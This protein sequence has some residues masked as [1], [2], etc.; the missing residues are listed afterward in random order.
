[1]TQRKS[2]NE[3]PK[4]LDPDPDG[5]KLAL[6]FPDF[7]MSISRPTNQSTI[8]PKFAKGYVT[9]HIKDVAKVAKVPG[10]AYCRLLEYALGI[11]KHAVAHCVFDFC[12]FLRITT[13]AAYIP[14][15]HQNLKHLTTVPGNEQQMAPTHEATILPKEAIANAMLAVPRYLE[16]TIKGMHAQTVTAVKDEYV[17]LSRAQKASNAK[18]QKKPVDLLVQAT[19]SPRISYW[20]RFGARLTNSDLLKADHASMTEKQRE[21]YNEHLEQLTKIAKQDTIKMLLEELATK[22]T[23]MDTRRTAIIQEATQVVIDIAQGKADQAE[24]RESRLDRE[25]KNAVATANNKRQRDSTAVLSE[26]AINKE[27]L[28]T[29]CPPQAPSEEQENQM[30][31]DT[32]PTPQAS[33]DAMDQER[34][35]PSPEPTATTMQLFVKTLDGTTT[36]TVPTNGKAK[37]ILAALHAKGVDTEAQ[38]LSDGTKNLRSDYTLA[39][40]GITNESTLVLQPRLRG[41]SGHTSVKVAAWNCNGGLSKK[42]D[43]VKAVMDREGIDIL[44]VS[45]TNFDPTAAPPPSR[46]HPGVGCQ[47]VQSWTP[48]P[49]DGLGSARPRSGPTDLGAPSDTNSHDNLHPGYRNHWHVQTPSQ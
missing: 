31:V 3:A 29:S 26:Y 19:K 38:R 22:A 23:A 1:M 14:S 11:P 33:T 39:N 32:A 24:A 47:L 4:K 48:D 34:P 42:M 36:V 27:L 7:S 20:F 15:F 10:N 40:H 12:G 30:Q 9:I 21:K 16:H 35:M 17:R 37:D 18:D 28:N 45:E 2:K 44:F 6:I 5:A 8:Q 41:G 43:F 25:D 13:H 46:L 49:W